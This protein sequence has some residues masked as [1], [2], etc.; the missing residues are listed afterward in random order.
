MLASATGLTT[1]KDEVLACFNPPLVSTEKT[2]TLFVPPLATKRSAPEE[3]KVTQV[4]LL[5]LAKGEPLN[6]V[7]VPVLSNE[8]PEILLESRFA[9]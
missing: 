8:N 6:A 1:T 7:R 3:S 5:A 2:E 4:G 9:V